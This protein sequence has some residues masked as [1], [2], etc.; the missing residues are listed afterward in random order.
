MLLHRVIDIFMRSRYILFFPPFF[1][2]AI[3][4]YIYFFFFFYLQTFL[5]VY[6][7]SFYFRDL[8]S[9]F[10]ALYFSVINHFK[11]LR[12]KHARFFNR[13]NFLLRC[14]HSYVTLKFLNMIFKL[15]SSIR[16]Q[17]AFKSSMFSVLK[18][19]VQECLHS[20]PC[21]EYELYILQLQLSKI[22]VYW[23]YILLSFALETHFCKRRLQIHMSQC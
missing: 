17:N 16:V 7:S 5:L 12:L 19:I 18:T 2:S 8:F 21:I 10:L 13:I 15:A 3:Y 1:I 20:L 11:Y 22:D 6:F 4:F 14:W 9:W 23:S